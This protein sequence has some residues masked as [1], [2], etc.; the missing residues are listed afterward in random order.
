MGEGF[1][2]AHVGSGT[3]VSDD[4]GTAPPE[5]RRPGRGAA[6]HATS[7]RRSTRRSAA[8]CSRP[9]DFRC[10]LPDLTRF[11]YETWRRLVSREIRPGD[12]RRATYGEAAGQPDLRAALARHL[13]VSRAVRATADDIVITNGVAAGRR[14]RRPRAAGAGRSGRRGGPRLPAAAQPAADD[15]HGR[16]AACPVDAE[17]LVVDAHPARDAARHRH[18]VAPVP[19]RPRHVAA[20]ADRPA[21][22]GRPQRRGDPRGRLRQRVPLRRPARRAAAEPRH[23]T[24]ASSTPAR[25]RRRCCRRCGSA[26]SSCRRRSARQFA[27]PSTSPTG[28]RRRRSNWRWPSS[29]TAAGSPATCGRCAP[30]T[31]SATTSSRATSTAS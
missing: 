24:G 4:V 17:G 2:V 7:G 25:S 29:S 9:F 26:S 10:G 19:A 16:R 28:R 8:R 20:P 6:P 21:A 3:Y 27:R 1:L 14:R 5:L 31:A 23:A 22:V 30:C 13:A 15:G 18:A 12:P 11:P